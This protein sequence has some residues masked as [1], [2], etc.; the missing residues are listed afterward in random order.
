MRAF[1]R[2]PAVLTFP[3]L[4]DLQVK[5]IGKNDRNQHLK[6]LLQADPV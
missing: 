4:I 6:S 2:H 3:N 5:K 1:N